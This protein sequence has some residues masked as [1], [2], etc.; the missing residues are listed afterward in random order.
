M[1][2]L[3]CKNKYPSVNV[4]NMSTLSHLSNP[5]SMRIMTIEALSEGL[6]TRFV[7]HQTP[8]HLCSDLVP[9]FC[10]ILQP[11]SRL[12]STLSWQIMFLKFSWKYKITSNQKLHS[13]HTTRSLTHYKHSPV[14]F[15]K[16]IKHQKAV[17]TEHVRK[18]HGHHLVV[19]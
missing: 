11:K 6:K 12:S 19:T 9:S 5:H 14:C 18:A 17:T 4:K 10:P 1:L 7:I 3:L 2:L 13:I 8:V 16:V 15:W